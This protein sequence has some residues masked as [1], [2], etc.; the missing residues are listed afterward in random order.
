MMDRLF[1]VTVTKLSYA[2]NLEQI[3][4]GNYRSPSIFIQICITKRLIDTAITHLRIMILVT[5]DRTP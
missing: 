5:L 2:F 4:W 1:G 3:K